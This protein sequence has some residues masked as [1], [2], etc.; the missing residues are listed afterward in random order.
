MF[1]GSIVALATPLNGG[2][3]DKEKLK[4]LV[5][6]QIKN[7]TQGI[8]SMGTTGEAATMS[9]EEDIEITA[10]VVKHV[11]GR[12]PVIAGTG[13]NSTREA[14]FLTEAAK[15]SGADAA[16]VV[17]PYYNKPTQEGLYQHFK[18]LAENVDIPIILYNVPSRTG[19]WLQPETMARLSKVTGIVAVKESSGG[20]DAAMHLLRLAPDFTVLSGD[21]NFTLPLMAL[22][23]KGVIS[24][25]ANVIPDKVSTLCRF[26]LNGDYPA[27]RKL[28]Y[29]L[30]DF[31]K[32]IFIESNP[33]PIKAAL[34][35]LGMIKEEYRLPLV[36]MGDANRE[37]L[38]VIMKD[39]GLS[40]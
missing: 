1:Q 4:E 13:S 30:L 24:V 20:V 28:H 26:M 19:V 27:A 21:D 36:P 14:L 23:A 25:A 34:A 10:L 11:N 29:E 5:D 40:V 35:L 38:K 9:H 37:R 16:L 6:F 2:Q 17:T 39:L 32:G 8:V 31:F 3:V 15:K 22:G 18:Y 7:G 33:I 12:I